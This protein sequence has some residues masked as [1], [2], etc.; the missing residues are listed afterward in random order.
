MRISY[1]ELAEEEKNPT[2]L[3]KRKAQRF[4]DRVF[5]LIEERKSTCIGLT[6]P[7]IRE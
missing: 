7:V 1:R 6:N 4:E 3:R 5:L 2:G